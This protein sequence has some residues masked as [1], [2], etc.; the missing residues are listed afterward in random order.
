[1]SELENIK[2]QIENIPIGKPF[3]NKSFPSFKQNV[4]DKALS[5]LVE[6][7]VIMKVTDGVFVRPKK[8]R[9]V[10]DVLPDVSLVIQLI[11]KDCGETIQVH[12]AEAAR[13]FGLTTQMSTT[14]VYYTNGK[15]REIQIGK[16]KVKLVHASDYRNLRHAGNKIGM[17]LAAL[18]YIGKGNVDNGVIRQ[19]KEKLTKEEFE[20]LC[21]SKMPKWMYKVIKDYIKEVGNEFYEY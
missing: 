4:I 14:P 10:G 6:E 18:Y 16:L 17:A 19:I 15:T 2:R 7:G 5:S 21:S 20:I 3:S 1:M 8:N 11:A 13:R 12:G 9:F